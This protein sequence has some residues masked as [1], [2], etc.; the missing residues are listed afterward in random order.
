MIIIEAIVCKKILVPC[1]KLIYLVQEKY[2][3]DFEFFRKLIDYV[4]LIVCLIFRVYW[5]MEYRRFLNKIKFLLMFV[6]AAL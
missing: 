2:L 6:F 4:T 1:Y 3:Y 5:M